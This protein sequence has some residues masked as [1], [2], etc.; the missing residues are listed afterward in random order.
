[1]SYSSLKKGLEL[2]KAL[3]NLTD[4]AKAPALFFCFIFF[5]NLFYNHAENTNLTVNIKIHTHMESRKLKCKFTKQLFKN[6]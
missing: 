1:M 6:A 2:Y 4:E 3:Y 5:V